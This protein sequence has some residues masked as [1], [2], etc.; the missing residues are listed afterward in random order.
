MNRILAE[1][2][3]LSDLELPRFHIKAIKDL[4]S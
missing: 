1:A 3:T 4:I 2:D